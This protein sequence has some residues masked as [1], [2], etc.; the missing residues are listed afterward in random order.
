MGTNLAIFERD[1]PQIPM[2]AL[3]T[4]SPALVVSPSLAVQ[5]GFAAAAPVAL[6]TVSM[7]ADSTLASF[8][9]TLAG[10]VAVDGGTIGL[11]VSFGAFLAVILGLFIPPPPQ[12]LGCAPVLAAGA[13]KRVARLTRR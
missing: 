1:R 6:P 13:G 7:S 8:S 2:F 10:V 3:L 9:E 4:S 5:R 11:D 12:A